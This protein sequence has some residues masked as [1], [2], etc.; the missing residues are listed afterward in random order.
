MWIIKVASARTCPPLMCTYKCTH[1]NY[2]ALIESLICYFS[3][4]L[5]H[6]GERVS[7]ADAALFGCGSHYYSESYRLVT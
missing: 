7:C 3:S 5:P 2:G 4:L 6:A 1:F